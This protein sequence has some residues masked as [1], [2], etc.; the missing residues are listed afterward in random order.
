MER[1]S[2]YYQ[3]SEDKFLSLI[4]DD[5]NDSPLLESS[6]DESADDGY[7]YNAE[8]LD[9]D[10]DQESSGSVNN[11][12]LQWTI[13]GQVRKRFIFTGNPGIQVEL[14]NVADP[15]EFFELCFDN[16]IVRLIVSK[17]NRYAEQFL[18][19]RSANLKT[20]S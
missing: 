18:E 3:V 1:P 11:N 2:K 10:T 6:E 8:V 5:D 17:T 9:S 20:R 16:E 7:L 12:D 19:E 15:L 13:H 14:R 4:L